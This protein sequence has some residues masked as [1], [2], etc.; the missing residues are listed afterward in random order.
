DALADRFASALQA[1]EIRPGDRVG[2]HLPNVP[3][4]VIAFYGALRAGA[5]A[6][7]CNPLYQQRELAHLLADSGTRVVVTLSKLYPALAAA[8]ADSPN[9]IR[10]VVVASIKE[11]FP[12][13]LAI[14]FTLLREAK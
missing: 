13:R 1:M 4:F 7:S 2:I 8:G 3:Q 9:G 14:P 6:V 12:A 5:V 10:E 11:Y